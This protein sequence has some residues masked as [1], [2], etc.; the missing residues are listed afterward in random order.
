MHFTSLNVLTFVF[1]TKPLQLFGFIDH[2][3]H[4][5]VLLLHAIDVCLKIIS[6]SLNNLLMGFM[7]FDSRLC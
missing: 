6:G 4:C 3:N 7:N 1:K 2:R 5:N